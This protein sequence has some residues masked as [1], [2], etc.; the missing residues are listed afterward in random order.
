MIINKQDLGAEMNVDQV[1]QLIA[2]KKLLSSREV[3]SAKQR[4]FQANRVESSDIK[5]FLKWMVLNKFLSEFQ[6]AVR[7]PCRAGFP[8]PPLRYGGPCPPCP[9]SGAS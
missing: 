1:I 4:W 3:E 6:A 2:E 9:R 7:P 8:E 5:L